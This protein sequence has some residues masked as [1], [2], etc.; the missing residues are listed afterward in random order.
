MFSRRRSEYAPLNRHPSF[1]LADWKVLAGLGLIAASILIG[2]VLFRD[3]DMSVV[4][5]QASRDMPA[6]VTVTDADFDPVRVDLGEVG[7][8]YAT[9]PSAG[10]LT[11]PML[12][13]ELLP[14]DAIGEAVDVEHRMLTLPVEPLHAPDISSGDLIDVWTTNQ[15]TGE[16]VLAISDVYVVSVMEDMIGAGGESGIVVTVPV[17]Q[18]DTMVAALRSGVVDVVRV[19]AV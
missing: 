12:A 16:T 10:V 15:E 4:A 5:W 3:D 2:V 17:T 11:R 13:G 6:G 8:G 14:R 7:G 19:P 9:E 1:S 18:I